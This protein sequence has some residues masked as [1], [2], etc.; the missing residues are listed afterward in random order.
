MIKSNYFSQKPRRVSIGE[1]DEISGLGGGRPTLPPGKK[2]VGG[3][4]FANKNHD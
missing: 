4:D 1:L 2:S 3:T